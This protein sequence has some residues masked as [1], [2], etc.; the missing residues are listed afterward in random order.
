M[1]QGRPTCLRGPAGRGVA[2]STAV[3][4]P[5][6]LAAP[7]L[8]AGAPLP[9][10]VLLAARVTLGLLPGGALPVAAA[11]T[12]CASWVCATAELSASRLQHL[13]KN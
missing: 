11:G 9:P 4:A 8:A 3:A 10:T 6:L 1:S 2:T 7:A 12:S 13:Q 5:A